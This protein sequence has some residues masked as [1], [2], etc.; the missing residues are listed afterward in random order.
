MSRLHLTTEPMQ[1]ENRITPGPWRWKGKD[2]VTDEA[3][4]LSCGMG[5]EPPDARLIRLAPLVRE[6]LRRLRRSL[7]MQQTAGGQWEREEAQLEADVLLALVDGDP[8]PCRGDYI[9][10]DLAK[11]GWLQ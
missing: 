9:L 7:L 5:P 8:V 6:S 10:Q 4:V 3:L 11:E 2:L 1:Q